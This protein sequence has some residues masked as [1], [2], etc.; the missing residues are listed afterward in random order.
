MARAA[1]KTSIRSL[2]GPVRSGLT[3]GL[4]LFLGQ[5]L[6]SCAGVSRALTFDPT[7]HHVRLGDHAYR[8]F[9]HPD[10]DAI[11]TT[12]PVGGAMVMGAAKGLTLGLANTMPPEKVHE[13][14]ARKY[15]DENGRAHCSITKGYLVAEPQYE[16]SYDCSR[17]P[18]GYEP[19]EQESPDQTTLIRADK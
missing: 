3:L 12:P 10:E 8:V 15:L 13:A 6:T 11:M 19:S 4:G 1:K 7:V 5:A 2:S 16:F 18:E 9:E 17:P 14:A